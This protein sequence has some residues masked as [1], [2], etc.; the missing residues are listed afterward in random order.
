MKKL[1]YMRAVSGKK[2]KALSSIVYQNGLWDMFDL[3][4][5]GYVNEGYTPFQSLEELAIWLLENEESIRVNAWDGPYKPSEIKTLWE[6]ENKY[7]IEHRI[8]NKLSIVEVD[9]LYR[10]ESDAGHTVNKW[11]GKTYYYKNHK[12]YSTLDTFAS[13][14]QIQDIENNDDK[15][16]YKFKSLNKAQDKKYY[17]VSEVIN[18]WSESVDTGKVDFKNLYKPPWYK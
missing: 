5:I 10:I 14:H 18:F 3:N 16:T 17:P 13:F 6:R 9:A 8:G 2:D 4:K 11:S 1:L 12:M 7:F 15:F